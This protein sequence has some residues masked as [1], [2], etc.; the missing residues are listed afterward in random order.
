MT[1]SGY[2]AGLNTLAF[3]QPLRTDGYG[4]LR[5]RRDRVSIPSHSGSLFGREKVSDRNSFAFVSIPSH[6]GSLFG[7]AELQHTVRRTHGLNTLAFGQPLRTRHHL[8]VGAE[9]QRLNTLA[10]GQPLR[11][12][13]SK[14]DVVEQLVS[15]PSHSGSLFGRR[16][17]G[18]VAKGTLVSIPSHSGSLFG[19]DVERMEIRGGCVSIPSHSGSLFGPRRR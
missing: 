17:I 16:A 12:L 19:H 3:G 2:A 13:G 8:P 18:I 1:N 7:R 6:S 14:A 15:I 5:D 11:T 10:F 4:H 9:L